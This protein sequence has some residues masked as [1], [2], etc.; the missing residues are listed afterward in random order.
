[1]M[2]PQT[3]FL[4]T[5]SRT[6]RTTETANTVGRSTVSR[7]GIARQAPG[8]ALPVGNEIAGEAGTEAQPP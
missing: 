3:G 8:S 4:F 1:M 2:K 7:Y 6:K 5:D